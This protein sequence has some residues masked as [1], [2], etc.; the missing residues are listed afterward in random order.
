MIWFLWE[1]KNLPYVYQSLRKYRLI[2]R[3]DNA[4]MRLTEKGR[5][6]GSGCLITLGLRFGKKTRSDWTWN[7]TIKIKLDLYHSPNQILLIQNWKRRLRMSITYS[8]CSNDPNNCV[9]RLAD[10]KNALEWT[11]RWNSCS[12]QV[13]NSG[14]I[15]GP[16]IT[17]SSGRYQRLRR[18]EILHTRIDLNYSRWKV[19]RNE[20]S[21]S[22]LS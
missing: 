5:E 1:P 7:T 10:L 13:Q 12:E 9:F 18:Q 14:K 3:E 6:L 4:D 15:R 2:L 17:S 16:Y 21:K 19:C 22:W 20:S 11:G 8:I